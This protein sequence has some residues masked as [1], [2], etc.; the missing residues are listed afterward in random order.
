MENSI[1]GQRVRIEKMMYFVFSANEDKKY[2]A[3]FRAKF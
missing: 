1:L 2:T 3:V